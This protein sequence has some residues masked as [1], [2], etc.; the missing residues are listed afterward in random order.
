MTRKPLLFLF[1]LVLALRAAAAAPDL[2]FEQR[3]GAQLPMGAVFTDETGRTATLGSYFGG[4]PVVL[5]FDYLRCPEMCSLVAGGAI[6]ALR[7]LKPSAGRDYVVLS[8]SIDP[9]DTVEMARTHQREDSLHYGRT[10]AAR[11]WHA[12]V[13][14]PA[15]IQALTA[16]AGFHYFYDPRSRQYAHPSGLLLAT[17]EG[18]VSSYFLGVD[19]PAAEMAPALRRAA[20]NQTGPSVFSLL[21]VCFQGGSPEGRY[22]ALIW[23]ILSISVALTVAAVFGGIFWLVR[24][25]RRVRAG[26]GGGA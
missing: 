4:K 14:T 21:F 26:A 5:V 6:D 3:I 11:G 22:G 1:G 13:G 2:R 8:V 16:A 25:E 24:A 23:T 17:P 18:I 12:L 20:A 19:F 7:Q 10:G 9:T 15:A